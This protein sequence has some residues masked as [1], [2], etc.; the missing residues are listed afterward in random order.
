MKLKEI[1]D[2]FAGLKVYEQRQQQDDYA[3]LVFFN[4]DLDAWT[5]ILTQDLGSAAKL[6][7][8]QPSENDLILTEPYG[9]ILENQILF[10]KKFP[11]GLILAMFW[12]WSDNEHTT[13]KI[14][15]LKK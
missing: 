2:K 6:P 4:K 9:G 3:E 11:Q 1:V 13:L 15:Q 10:K 14:A 5:R 12:P 8:A 7:G